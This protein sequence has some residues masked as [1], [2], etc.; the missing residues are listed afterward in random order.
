MAAHAGAAHLRRSRPLL[1]RGAPGGR[2]ADL[3]L[4]IHLEAGFAA[5]A[6]D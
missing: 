4:A 1:G 2:E 6:G 5:G 3:D